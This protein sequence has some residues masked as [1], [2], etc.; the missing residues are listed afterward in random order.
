MKTKEE[1]QVF[2]KKKLKRGYPEGELINDLLQEGYSNDEIQ[3]AI[4]EPAIT[5]NGPA[6]QSRQQTSYP[7][8][9][10]LT[11]AAGVVGLS[12]I[13]VSL[14]RNNL[15]WY[16]LLGIGLAGLLIRFILPLINEGKKKKNN[17]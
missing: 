9:F 7:T 12:F 17:S 16:I 2:V 13:S 8:W 4:Y 3:K 10:V 5:D 1:L 6:K 14:F 11:S 15:L